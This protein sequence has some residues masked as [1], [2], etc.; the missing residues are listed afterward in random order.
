MMRATGRKVRATGV[1][2]LLYVLL[3]LTVALSSLSVPAVAT[4]RV[5]GNPD[6]LENA[7][8]HGVNAITTTVS[9][10][11]D[12]KVEIIDKLSRY[13]V[14]L[15]IDTSTLVVVPQGQKVWD[16]NKLDYVDSSESANIW[17][18]NHKIPIKIINYSDLAIM[19]EGRATKLHES[20]TYTL[21]G[22]PNSI[23]DGAFILEGGSTDIDHNKTYD[24]IT[25]SSHFT[26][27]ISDWDAMAGALEDE[28]DSTGKCSLGAITIVVR[29][30]TIN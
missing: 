24:P 11:S 25:F 12:I 21:S 17:Y 30:S 7:P 18:A 13:A 2:R 3:A 14:D 16:V 4:D 26:L 6:G 19:V 1:T 5:V 29:P 27:S 20:N 28:A 9:Q 22:F 15:E 10:G 23:V 8:D